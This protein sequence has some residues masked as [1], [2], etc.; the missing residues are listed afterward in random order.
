ML[1]HSQFKMI[2]VQCAAFTPN[3]AAF[4]A[5]R[6]IDYVMRTHGSLL[7]GPPAY[8]PPPEG[9]PQAIPHLIQV[10]VR[11]TNGQWLV[12]AGSGRLDAYWNSL[13]GA[14]SYEDQLTQCGGLVAS[15]IRDNG[16]TATQVGLGITR[17]LVVDHAI[18][19]MVEQFCRHEA[20]ELFEGV[21]QFAIQ[22]FRRVRLEGVEHEFNS[23]IRCEVG[24][25]AQNSQ[26][27]GVTQDVNDVAPGGPHETLTYDQLVLFYQR[28]YEHATETFI[29]FFPA[30]D[31]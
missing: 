13:D 3:H 9:M 12:T 2:Q 27:V 4:S 1:R 24:I 25:N 18:D 26:V 28:A 20:R 21:N 23:S 22:S 19:Q 16:V 7:D 11:S 10:T 15:Y 30:G 14:V 31:E 5:Q 29:R 17:G 6:F 8:M